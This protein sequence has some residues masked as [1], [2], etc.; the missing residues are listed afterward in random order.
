MIFVIDGAHRLGALAAWYH[1]DYGDGEISQKFYDGDISEEEREI[2]ERAR[3]LIHKKIGGA[4]KDFDGAN[5]STTKSAEHK[6]IA[7]NLG[8]FQLN[9]QWVEGDVKKAEDSFFKINE[10]GVQL[11]K[12]EIKLLRSRRKGN[13]IAARAIYKGGKGHKFWAAFSAD[14]QNLIQAYAKEIHQILFRPP[15]RMP[16]KNADLP[17]AGKV[18]ASLPIILDFINI[19]NGIPQD[20]R[21]EVEDDKSGDETVRYLRNTRK[22]AWRINSQHISSLGLDPIVYF[23]SSEGLHRAAS[24]RAIVALIV[25]MADNNSFKEFVKVRADFEELLLEY[26]Y[27][28]QDIGRKS[29]MAI[30]S[31]LNIKEFYKECLKGLKNKMKIDQAVNSSMKLEKFKYLKISPPIEYTE[32]PEVTTEKKSAIFIKKALANRLKCIHCNARLHQNSLSFDHII[33]K[34]EGGLGTIENVDIVHPYCNSIRQ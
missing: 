11:D 7:S 16:I 3:R 5:N 15:L 17:I 8:A 14:N 24:F 33:P 2:A 12:T 22:I 31:Y 1:N 20:F 9:V 28:V 25:E 18:S 29:R 23:Y 13:C 26:N 32:N 19:V 30:K 34:R 10:Q 27:M 6:R 21:E 4:Y